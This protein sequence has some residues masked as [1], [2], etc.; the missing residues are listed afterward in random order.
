MGDDSVIV[1]AQAG[2]DTI[3]SGNGNDT[4]IGGA[5]SD[6]LKGGRGN[7]IYVYNRGDGRDTI[8]DEYRY[9]S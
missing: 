2:D 6:I 5:G 7:D 3:I 1:D 9:G 8:V 4:L